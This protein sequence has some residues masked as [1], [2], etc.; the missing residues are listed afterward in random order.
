MGLFS[1]RKKCSTCGLPMTELFNGHICEYCEEQKRLV[2]R[3]KYA[4]QINDI[5]NTPNCSGRFISGYVLGCSGRLE[6]SPNKQ[7]Y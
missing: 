4:Q 7:T 1:K 5:S 2:N 3:N 6:S